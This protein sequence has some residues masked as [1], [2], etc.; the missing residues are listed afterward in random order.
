MVIEHIFVSKVPPEEALTRAS[1]Y[2]SAR[3]F[4]VPEGSAAF[5]LDGQTWSALEMTR[6]RV[7]AAR[8]KNVADLPQRIRIECNR[9]KID[10][11]MNITPS[12]VWGGANTGLGISSRE[13]KPKKMVLHTRM[14]TAIENGLAQLLAYNGT[15]VAD[16]TE[17]DAVEGE[18]NK[19]ARRRR[20]R[21]WIFAGIFLIFVVGMIMVVA[22]A[23]SPGRR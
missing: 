9:G 4:T 22:I 1:Q 2:L 10:V 5:A 7:K 6:G 18:I 12:L 3:G 11:A 8:A 14:L 23:A 17:W 16:Y 20:I 13:G 21:N 19:V 15:Q